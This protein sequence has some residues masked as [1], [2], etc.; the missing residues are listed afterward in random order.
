MV[1]CL[2]AVLAST[3][4][5]WTLRAGADRVWQCDHSSGALLKSVATPG[6]NLDGGIGTVLVHWDYLPFPPGI[7]QEVRILVR[8]K[9]KGKVAPL[10]LASVSGE[11]WLTLGLTG[12]GDTAAPGLETAS[13]AWQSPDTQN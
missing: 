12:Y 8:Q 4:H 11:R 7:L 9:R 1:D 13:E 6:E 3:T 2:L 10:P 5:G